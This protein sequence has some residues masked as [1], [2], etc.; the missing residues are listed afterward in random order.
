MST[1]EQDKKTVLEYVDAFNRGDL[2][3]LRARFAEDA[4]I[5]GVMG[6]GLMDKGMP[7]WGARD[8]AAQMRQIGVPLE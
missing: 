4:G 2:A 5:Q 8:S 3:R 1:P 7:N 6:K